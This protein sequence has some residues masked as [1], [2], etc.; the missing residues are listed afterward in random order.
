LRVWGRVPPTEAVEV[1]PDGATS[2]AWP[3]GAGESLDLSALDR[4]S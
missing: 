3:Q 4:L 1:G 2:A